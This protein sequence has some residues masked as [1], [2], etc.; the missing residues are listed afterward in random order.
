RVNEL[1]PSV[2]TKVIQPKKYAARHYDLDQKV[3][4]ELQ[5][6]GC[7]LVILDRYA[8]RLSPTFIM[9][10][11]GRLLSIYS[12]LLPAFRH[13]SSPIRD[14]LQAGVRITGVTVQFIGESDTDNDGPIIAQESISV[15]PIETENQLE[16]R[17]RILEQQLYPKAIDMVASG[18]IVYQGKRRMGKTNSITPTIPSSY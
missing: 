12:S 10:W 18:K 1:Y 17:L 7:E 15:S 8:C 13:S 14:A 5:L 3:D 9:T 4:D 16:S 11:R 2:V 6:H